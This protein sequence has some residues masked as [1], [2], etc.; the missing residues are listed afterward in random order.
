MPY[1][2]EYNQEL[3]TYLAAN[4]AKRE[5]MKAQKSASELHSYSLEEYGLSKAVVH[6]KFKD[7]IAK[8]NL[9]E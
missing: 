3:D 9:L 1:S 7:Y 4:K 8:F 6:E 5:A 2:N